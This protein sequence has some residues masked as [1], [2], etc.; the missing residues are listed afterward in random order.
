[1]WTF[2]WML[3]VKSLISML[4]SQK[5]RQRLGTEDWAGGKVL[6]ALGRE[7]RLDCYGHGSEGEE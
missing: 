5:H 7:N 2:M 6:I 4:Q 3:E 1:M